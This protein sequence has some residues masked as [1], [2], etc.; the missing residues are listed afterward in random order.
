MLIVAKGVI[1]VHREDKRMKLV[2]KFE[3]SQSLLKNV[4]N[5]QWT[6]EVL[7]EIGPEKNPLHTHNFCKN[8]VCYK[9]TYPDKCFSLYNSD[10]IGCQHYLHDSDLHI[11]KK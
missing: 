8:R 9:V 3:Q 4:N 7:T 6:T 11:M 10:M 1:S 5:L 2:L